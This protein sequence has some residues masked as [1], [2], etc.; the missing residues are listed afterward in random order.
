MDFNK[1]AARAKAILLSPTTEWP[2]IASEPA[3]VSEIFKTYVVWL[4]AISAVAGFVASTIVG[5]SVPFLGTYRM[6]LEK[7][8]K[9]A[10]RMVHERWN[11][12]A[13]QNATGFG[14]YG[15]IVGQRYAVKAS[16]Q[17]ADIDTLRSAVESVDLASL[18]ALRNE[19]VPA[20]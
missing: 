5:Y 16:G 20:K 13:G 12:P 3:T 6:G 2:A 9:S 18:E 17:V 19:G 15:V 8:Y 14:E 4:A 7:T 10:T 1:L 11:R